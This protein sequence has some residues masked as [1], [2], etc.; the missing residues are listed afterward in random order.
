MT[1]YRAAV[2]GLGWTGLLY[3][4]APRIPDRFDIDD[5]DRHTPPLD[6]HRKFYHHNHPGEEGNPTS[7]AQAL[8][9]RPEV[10]LVAGADRDKKRLQAFSERY[11]IK[12]LYTSASEMLRQEKPAIVAVCTN[13]VYRADLTCLADILDYLAGGLDEP[14]NSGRRVAVALEVEIALKQ[15]SAQGGVR[16]DLPLADRTLGLHYDWFR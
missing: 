10:K 8:W 16:V 12:A 13:T 3:D 5:V 15:S 4:L 2:I 1:Q 14:K 11:G 7:Y 9:N 6:V